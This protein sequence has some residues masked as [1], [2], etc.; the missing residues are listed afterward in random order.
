M[1]IACG[2]VHRSMGSCASHRPQTGVR[3]PVATLRALPCESGATVEAVP[4]SVLVRFG[5]RFTLREANRLAETLSTFRPLPK[6]TLD[7]KPVR[8]FDVSAIVPLATAIKALHGARVVLQ[9]L[10]ATQSRILRYFG[11]EQP[12]R[13]ASADSDEACSFPTGDGS[14]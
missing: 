5:R 2:T 7:F 10:T 13:E 14:R 9:G 6:L 11:V 8:E 4:G 3:M 12:R 1:T